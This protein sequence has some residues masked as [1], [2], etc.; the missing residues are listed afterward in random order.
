M[1]YYYY[2][3]K[4]RSKIN[5]DVNKWVAVFRLARLV[6]ICG[7]IPQNYWGK[8]FFI[9]ST[10]TSLKW[11]RDCPQQPKIH[12][13]YILDIKKSFSTPIPIE[14]LCRFKPHQ[15]STDSIFAFIVFK[16]SYITPLSRGIGEMNFHLKSNH[17]YKSENDIYH[18]K[19]HI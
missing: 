3:Y 13:R 18:F 1:F 19:I 17:Y 8:V 9:C 4:T 6:D 14:V 10:Q 5:L 11:I 15:M 16:Y 2:Y 7:D 12:F